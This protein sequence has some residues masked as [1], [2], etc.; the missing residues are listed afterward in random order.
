M[1]SSQPTLSDRYRGSP[2]HLL[3]P[4]LAGVLVVVGVSQFD[5][6][7]MALGVGLGLY[8]WLTRHTRYEIFSDRL[9]IYYGGPRR[10][11]VLLV[12]IEDVQVVKVPMGGQG[13]Y[14]RRK[15]GW[16]VVIRPRDSEGFAAGLEE[17][18]SRLAE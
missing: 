4:A 8:V 12:D 16:G 2:M 3:S 17:A 14:L 15:R 6:F 5:L 7:T 9:V 1:E 18:R 13:L 10:K 11:V